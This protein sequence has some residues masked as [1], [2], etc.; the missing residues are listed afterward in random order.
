MAEV[1]LPLIN[2]LHERLKVNKTVLDADVIGTY[3]DRPELGT[4]A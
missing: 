3:V 2:A 1:E 4:C